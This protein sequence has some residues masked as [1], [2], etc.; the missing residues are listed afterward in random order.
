LA[1]RGEDLRFSRI[2]DSLRRTMTKT[3]LPT[4]STKLYELLE[5]LDPPLRKRA[6]KAALTMLG[7]DDGDVEPTKK[8][9]Q[10]SD[11]SDN[12]DLPAKAR[13]WMK[14]HKVSQDQLDLMFHVENGVADVI[15]ADA[16]GK[17]GKEKTINCYILAGVAALL[18]SGEPKFDDKAGRAVA[19]KLGCYSSG[20]HA[21]YMKDRGNVLSGSKDG[22]WSLT[23][24]GLKAGADL[25][26]TAATTE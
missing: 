7:D 26:K 18:Q 13:S 23:G 3:D 25:V 11:D 8:A 22:G 6:I 14:T 24:P 4:V 5:P 12:S 20:N 10:K 16:P 21:T 9:E 17:N 2:L 19:E 1:T 15:A